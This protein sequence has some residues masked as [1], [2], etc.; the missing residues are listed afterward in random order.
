MPLITKQQI[1]AQSDE[2]TTQ[3][4]SYLLKTLA[5]V[6]FEG[7]DILVVHSIVQKLTDTLKTKSQ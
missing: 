1:T 5:S 6:T 7:K 3:E 2:L 4:I